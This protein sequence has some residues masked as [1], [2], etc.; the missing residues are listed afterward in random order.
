MSIPRAQDR[1][2]PRPTSAGRHTRRRWGWLPVGLRPPF[3]P[4]LP[5]LSHPDCRS[6]LTL[7]VAVQPFSL[8][9][10]RTRYLLHGHVVPALASVCRD[11]VPRAR[12]ECAAG[13]PRAGQGARWS[14][15]LAPRLTFAPSTSRCALRCARLR[16]LAGRRRHGPGGTRVP[17]GPTGHPTRGKDSEPVLRATAACQ[18]SA[19]VA[20]P[21]RAPRHDRLASAWPPPWSDKS[22][23]NSRKR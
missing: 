11:G 23:A 1:S 9:R 4:L 18:H 16:S 7:I 12:S 2:I 6:V 17:I 15:R 5:A 22:A 19:T 3:D 10:D 14:K 20:T 21:I 8:V 13:A